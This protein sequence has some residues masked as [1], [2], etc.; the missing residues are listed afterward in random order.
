[1]KSNHLLALVLAAAVVSSCGKKDEATSSAPLPPAGNAVNA[2]AP[3]STSDTAFAKLPGKWLRPDGGYILEIVSVAPDGTLDA[4]YLNP[5]P[6][7]VAKAV[8]SQA[9]GS[10]KA[11]IEL[12]DVNYPGSTYTLTYDP[13]KDQLQGNYFQAAI[14]QDFDVFF[15]RVKP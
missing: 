6:I 5:R 1:M 13:A 4:A 8:A 10:V 2:P 3:S 9:G 7:H 14:R 11:F 12:R 15:T